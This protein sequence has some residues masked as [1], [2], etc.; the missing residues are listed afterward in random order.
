MQQAIRVLLL[1]TGQM[2]SGI[3]RLVLRKAGLQLVGAFAR[4]RERSGRDLGPL[5]GLEEKLDITVQHD[6][7]A[8]IQQTRPQIAI[9]A[10]CSCLRDARDEILSLLREGV[11]VI[12]IAEEMAYPASASP[13][14]TQ[15]LRDLALANKVAL[16]GTGVNPGFVL[17]LLVIALTGVCAEVR[18]IRASRVNDLTPYGPTVLDSQG[19]G[20]SPAAFARGLAAGSVVGHYGFEQSIAMIGHALGWEIEQIEQVREPI[21]SKV[22]RATPFVMVEPGQVAG[23]HHRAVAFS[24]GRPVITLDHPQQIQPELEGIATG[25]RIEIEGTPDVAIAGSPEIPGGVATQALAVNMIPRVL[26]ASAG[27]YSMADLPV[28]AALLGDVRSLL[29]V[30]EYA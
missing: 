25:D 12:S 20:L 10:T 9:Q 21:I 26:N 28:P 8:V 7:Q 17:D 14:I 1:G 23:C 6:L 11:S 4:R 18:A 5:I 24:Q 2:G 27:L 30:N 13:Q 16:L 29:K 19:V 22:R 3:A 15:Q